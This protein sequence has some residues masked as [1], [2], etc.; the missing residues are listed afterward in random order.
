MGWLYNLIVAD[1]GARAPQFAEQSAINW[2]DS[3]RFEVEREH[4]V[5]VAEQALSVR[6]I[7]ENV[8]LLPGRNIRKLD[9]YEALFRAVTNV[10][11]LQRTGALDPVAWHRPA[12]A[13]TWYYTVY[14][15][16]TAMFAAMAQ[17]VSDNHTAARR[18]YATMLQ[19]RMPHPFNMVAH[20]RT[21]EKYAVMLP[22]Y[23]KA[24][25]YDIGG[26]FVPSAA[27]AQGMLLEYLS[28][29]SRWY[30]TRTKDGVL[31]QNRGKFDSFHT[32]KAREARDKA[33]EAKVGFLHCAYRY[34]TKANYRD[35]VFLTYGKRELSNAP[36]FITALAISA[37][38]LTMFTL[39]FVEHLLGSGDMRA[40]IQD[41]ELNVRSRAQIATGNDFWTALQFSGDA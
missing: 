9:V 12:A 23:P 6:L 7:N 22:D 32:A 10:L 26:T 11:S 24:T 17:P 28:G 41:L 39:T 29:T 38:F 30:A 4:G 35:G 37:R 5:S 31:R 34:R 19:E 15:C 14:S 33:L 20:R 3:I 40:F 18:L 16:A 36:R 1:E 27:V 2:A 13:V 21:G 25:K 8:K